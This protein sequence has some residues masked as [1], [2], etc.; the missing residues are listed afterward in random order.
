[1]T[2]W[3][4]TDDAHT[5]LGSIVRR[6]P[7][8]AGYLGMEERRASDTEARRWIVDRL[9]SSD[10]DSETD[11]SSVEE[12][13]DDEAFAAMYNNNFNPQPGIKKIE[14]ATLVDALVQSSK[15]IVTERKATDRYA[16]K[17]EQRRNFR[18]Y[19]W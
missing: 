1:M 8:F 10:D 3:F 14:T 13:S 11:E 16:V 5:T 17:R 18:N 4:E 19:W 2:D 7:G 15:A 9:D 6:I 12:N